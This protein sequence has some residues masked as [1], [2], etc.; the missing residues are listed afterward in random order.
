MKRPWSGWGTIAEDIPITKR[1]KFIGKSILGQ[2]H[3]YRLCERPILLFGTRRGGSTLLMRA[4]ATQPHTDFSNEPLN[5][6]LF[7]PHFA[8]LP[9]P[10]RSRFVGL[11][12]DDERLLW[13]FFE[14]L[15][16]GKIKTFNHWRFWEP[17]FSRTV[18]RLVVKVLGANNLIDEFDQRF[19]API[20]YLVRH[21]IPV[22]QSA[23]KRNWGND[24]G[25]Y[26]ANDAIW[27]QL[28]SEA[29]RTFAREVMDR[30]SELQRYV[31]E[32]CLE[33]VVPLKL[34][35]PGVRVSQV[36]ISAGVAETP[37]PLAGEGRDEG[38]SR[39]KRRGSVPSPP[40]WPSPVKGEG[41]SACEASL[42]PIS[43]ALQ[44]P[45]IALAWIESG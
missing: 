11:D 18:H 13:G 42:T 8:R 23:I 15:L 33:N 41:N 16:S 7:N 28:G 26:L 29:T 14:D 43:S 25:A 40:P 19:D 38:D 36:A 6:W 22:A 27:A 45:H 9:H 5:L 30:G 24:V 2:L 17:D 21:P 39:A 1:A 3:R 10:P 4:L 37:S 32:W 35:I 12:S 20:L 31:L 34:S 44:N